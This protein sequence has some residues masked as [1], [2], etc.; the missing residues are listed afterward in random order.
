MNPCCVHV[1]IYAGLA[2]PE[3]GTDRAD[4][5][6]CR[7]CGIAVANVP[8]D[9][10]QSDKTLLLGGERRLS[11]R[12]CHARIWAMSAICSVEKALA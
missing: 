3:L 11:A 2:E 5:K 9:A 7:R 8:P 10:S 4:L 1:P 6:V 12:R